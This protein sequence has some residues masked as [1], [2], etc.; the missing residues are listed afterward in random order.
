M[1]MGSFDG[2]EIYELV[3]LYILHLLSSKFNKDEGLYRDDGLVALEIS[4]PQ[5]DRARKNAMACHSTN[6]HKKASKGLCIKVSCLPG[7]LF[8]MR[9]FKITLHFISYND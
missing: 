4:V 7:T 2:A 6:V 9:K 5:S 1:T 3:G 8:N